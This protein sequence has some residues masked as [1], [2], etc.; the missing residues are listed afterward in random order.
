MNSEFV[1]LV[2]SHAQAQ[3]GAR[4]YFLWSSQGRYPASTGF[5]LE[6][7]AQ[8]NAPPGDYNL[9]FLIDLHSTFQMP[10][11]NGV[12]PIVKLGSGSEIS[13]NT[14]SNQSIVRRSRSS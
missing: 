6:P 8:P 10:P 14:V 7:F 4:Y 13:K 1:S 9:G 3:P 2:R 5:A 11:K 12:M